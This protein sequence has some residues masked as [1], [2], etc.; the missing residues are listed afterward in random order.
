MNLEIHS[1]VGGEKII[2]KIGCQLVQNKNIR[3][4][5][6]IKTIDVL[7]NLLSWF[8]DGYQKTIEEKMKLLL[9]NNKIATMINDK[10]IFINC[11]KTFCNDYIIIP[12]KNLIEN[13][14]KIECIIST[15]IKLLCKEN[16]ICEEQTMTGGNL[17]KIVT[18]VCGTTFCHIR[19]NIRESFPPLFESVIITILTVLITDFKKGIEI[20]KNKVNTQI[21]IIKTLLNMFIKYNNLDK[22]FYKAF[23]EIVYKLLVLLTFNMWNLIPIINDKIRQYCK[24]TNEPDMKYTMCNFKFPLSITKTIQKLLE[25]DF[26]NKFIENVTYETITIKYKCS[27]DENFFVNSYFKNINYENEYKKCIN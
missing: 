5:M 6:I 2:K 17:N 22:I 7:S 24:K 12:I 14:K 9:S 21:K 20:I 10:L 11:V 18:F 3:N 23:N 25:Y 13:N 16:E 1:L 19:K 4:T 27:K 8:I 15:F 26:D